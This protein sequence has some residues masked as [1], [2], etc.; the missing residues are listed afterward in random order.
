MLAYSSIAHAGYLLIALVAGHT[1]G[2][3]SLLFYLL[4]YAFMN[5]GAFSVV[6]AL[7]RKGERYLQLSDYAGLGFR[8]PLLGMAMGL[9]MFSLSG[10]P[11]TAGFMA[12]FYVF[13]AAV[14]R[15]YIGLA[16]IGVLNSLV[17]IYYYLRPIVLMY[18]EEP[19]AEVPVLHLS[20]YV[21]AA[22][23]VAI[24]GTIQLGL[25]PSLLLNLAQDA[26]R[27][28]LGS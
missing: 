19:K 20:P 1:A 13:S 22:L 14:E 8:F 23:V 9:F 16:I 5:L 2:F 24:L 3:M 27:E 25:F 10:L 15:G 6:I 4:A 21:V 18:M 12:K 26:A 7:E 11:P 28:L 17:S